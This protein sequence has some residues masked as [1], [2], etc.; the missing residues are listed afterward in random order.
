MRSSAPSVKAAIVHAGHYSHVPA[1]GKNENA[2][3]SKKPLQRPA[4]GQRVLW[5]IQKRKRMRTHQAVLSMSC[6]IV[7][8]VLN[9]TATAA[10]HCMSVR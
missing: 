8:C 9:R 5:I 2:E 10:C 4:D 7:I 1:S 3:G 6:L